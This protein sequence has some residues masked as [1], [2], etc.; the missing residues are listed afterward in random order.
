MQALAPTGKLAGS[1][2]C[3]QLQFLRPGSMQ[4]CDWESL[5][6]EE[7]G[8]V[9]A[10][11]TTGIIRN[12]QLERSQT[13]TVLECAG[14]ISRLLLSVPIKIGAYPTG[15]VTGCV[16]DTATAHTLFG[17]NDV[18][19]YLLQYK[20]KD[21]VITGVLDVDCSLLLV[22]ADL[23]VFE[24]TTGFYL[25]KEDSLFPVQELDAFL[26]QYGF[27][28]NIVD[29]GKLWTMLRFIALLPMWVCCVIFAWRFLYLFFPKS[30][31]LH[32]SGLVGAAYLSA[33]SLGLPSPIT[34]EM[35]PVEWSDFSLWSQSVDLIKQQYQ[36]AWSVPGSIVGY[37]SLQASGVSVVAW[38]VIALICFVSAAPVRRY[39]TPEWL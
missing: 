15:A 9:L 13:A 30:W 5:K 35:T 26:S 11:E 32:L 6:E 31:A 34:A 1:T 16:I 19:G 36:A 12:A 38:S 2:T 8:W 25:P 29:Q 4:W 3:Y 23:N 22:W 39:T 20:E 18:V 17:N 24:P 33:R 28:A 10:Q 21:Y 7:A 27:E 37:L 14:D